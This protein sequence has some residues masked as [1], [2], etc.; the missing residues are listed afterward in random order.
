MNGCVLGHKITI[1]KAEEPGGSLSLASVFGFGLPVTVSNNAFGLTGLFLDADVTIKASEGASATKFNVII[2]DLPDKVTQIL[3]SANTKRGSLSISISLGYLD[4]PWLNKHNP[5][6]RGRVLRIG[7]SVADD[8][9]TKVELEGL[10]E[11]GYLLLGKRASAVQ[12]GSGNLDDVV[13]KLLDSVKQAPS[14]KSVPLASGS[15]L[16]GA[17]ADFTVRSGSIMSALA[18]IT[19]A[20]KKALVVDYGVVAI[21]PAVGSA[22][23][24]VDVDGRDNV[25]KVDEQAEADPKAALDEPEEVKSGSKVTVLGHPGLRVGQMITS[26][27]DGSP[28]SLRII[29]LKQLY[30]AKSG[31]VC[32]L[33][34]ADVK[35]GIRAPAAAPA[36]KLIDRFNKAMLAARQDNP[37]VDVGEVTSYTPADGACEGAAHR[38]TMRYSQVPEGEV[39]APS[40]DSPISTEDELIKKPMASAFAFDKVGLVTPVYPG[41]RALLA[42]NRSLTNDAVI[43]GWLWPSKPASAPPPNKTGDWWL[44]LPTE[45]GSDNRP[46]GKGVNDLTDARGARVLQARALHILVGHSALPEV[47]TRPDVPEDDTITIEHS[48]GTTIKIDAQGAVTVSTKEKAITLTNGQVT[49]ALDGNSVDVK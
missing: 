47:G 29:A 24:P 45:L 35:P 15:T 17:A 49:L 30:S 33:V 31:Y 40:T 19:E 28:K 26:N 41:M 11:A 37:A 43:T 21:G 46:T 10:E 36:N 20:A 22:K 14:N 9:R 4:S 8:G 18:Q 44:A 2:Y 23:A 32:E 6:L 27:A 13:L 48:S 12:R 39:K 25:V 7:S 3:R 5:V 16:G 34:L 42:H 38:V 1:T